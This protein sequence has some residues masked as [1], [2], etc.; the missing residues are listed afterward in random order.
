MPAPEIDDAAAAAHP[1]HPPR[2]LPGFVQFLARQALGRD[3]PPA[4]SDRTATRREPA[5]IVRGQPAVRGARE[6]R[7][8]IRHRAS[9]LTCPP[10][11]AMAP[12]RDGTLSLSEDAPHDVRAAS[13]L[14]W[15]FQAAPRAYSGSR[16]S[17]RPAEHTD[18][19]DRAGRGRA[20]RPARAIA[21]DGPADPGAAGREP[22]LA[23]RRRCGDADPRAAAPLPEVAALLGDLLAASNRPRGCRWGLV[24]IVGRAALQKAGFLIPSLSAFA[25]A[26]APFQPPDPAAAVRALV[27]KLDDVRPWWPTSPWWRPV[28]PP[29]PSSSRRRP[30][31]SA[32]CR[33]RCRSPC[34]NPNPNS[35]RPVAGPA[36]GTASPAV[37]VALEVT[38]RLRRGHG[39][40][41]GGT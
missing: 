39:G 8:G 21:A 3:R 13:I 17:R 12:A 14:V 37:A 15:M 11:R 38:P 32:R 40:R 36:T 30:R 27:A 4:R 41:R 7:S 25:A 18:R 28:T 16:L 9:I 24:S 34:P 22:R 5:E 33:P 19:A 31:S 23:A 2:H 35:D 6:G 20:H 10:G 29:R 1:A 26:L